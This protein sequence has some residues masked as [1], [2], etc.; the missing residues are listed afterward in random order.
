M[1]IYRS[2]FKG[3][4]KSPERQIYGIKNGLL[5]APIDI[6]IYESGFNT[7]VR[8]TP[9]DKLINLINAPVNNTADAEMGTIKSFESPW[10]LSNFKP[11]VFIKLKKDAQVLI[12]SRLAARPLEVR[13]GDSVGLSMNRFNISGSVEKIIDEYPYLRPEW[14]VQAYLVKFNRKLTNNVHGAPVVLTSS[15]KLLGMLIIT[16][17]N[18]T[19]GNTK[20]LVFPAHLI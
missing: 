1:G 13:E 8:F 17:D 15:N 11:V 5:V 2:Q 18:M 16:E 4:E 20:A 19:N 9:V 3:I 6:C 12:P 7:S 10:E 14:R